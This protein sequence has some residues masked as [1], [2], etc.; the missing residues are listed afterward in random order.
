MKEG[1]MFL[2]I[3]REPQWSGPD[4]YKSPIQA[5]SSIIPF[6]CKFD[7]A[8]Y[9]RNILLYL[10]YL[11]SENHASDYHKIKEENYLSMEQSHDSAGRTTKK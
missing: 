4:L 1:W 6:S 10:W 5:Y 3:G 11:E 8:L 7:F 9:N 2:L